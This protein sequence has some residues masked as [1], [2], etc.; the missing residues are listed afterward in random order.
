MMTSSDMLTWLSEWYLSQCNGDWEHDY[1]IKIETLDN[2]G[3]SLT[4][5]IGYP[6]TEMEEPAPWTL[7]EHGKD[8]WYGFKV[9]NGK[10][11]AAGDPTK[12]ALLISKFKEFIENAQVAED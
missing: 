10:F 7:V 9:E 1:G 3:W 11:D 5:D 8:D 2:P 4:V 6:P 12:L